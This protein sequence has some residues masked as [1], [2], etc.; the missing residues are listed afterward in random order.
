LASLE[1]EKR[2][3]EGEDE[4]WMWERSLNIGIVEAWSV[5]NKQD[6]VPVELRLTASPIGHLASL[7]RP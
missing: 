4:V 5:A 6:S 3:G 2:K 7:T 1:G